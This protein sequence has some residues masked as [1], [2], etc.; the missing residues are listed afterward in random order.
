[1]VAL[2]LALLSCT[3]GTNS[4]RRYKA[5]ADGS[6][7]IRPKDYF[8]VEAPAKITIV[9]VVSSALAH[10]Y[11]FDGSPALVDLGAIAAEKIKLSLDGTLLTLIGDSGFF[12]YQKVTAETLVNPGVTVPPTELD[13]FCV[14]GQSNSS[15]QFAGATFLE[16]QIRKS[17][18][19][20]QLTAL[21][22]DQSLPLGQGALASKQYVGNEVAYNLTNSSSLKI[23]TDSVA[24]DAPQYFNTSVTNLRC[25]FNV[26]YSAHTLFLTAPLR[27]SLGG[28]AGA[29]STCAAFADAGAKTKGLPGVWRAILSDSNNDVRNR[30]SFFPTASVKNAQGETIVSDGPALWGGTLSS[31]IKYNENGVTLNSQSAWTG[32]NSDGTRA[33]GTDA[34]MSCSAWTSGNNSEN[35]II[36]DA[37]S[38]TPTWLSAGAAYVD[39]CGS[40]GGHLHEGIY[41]INSRD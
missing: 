15:A 23:F 27:G 3:A 32:S 29:D 13:A 36:G 2:G 19:L 26:G 10:K 30:I 31:A 37:N 25:R 8:R 24:S 34:S 28:L 7:G 38:I 1:M 12:E 11:Y 4:S 16:L 20:F 40:Q 22:G 9:R 6:L 5:D 21:N 14:L 41:C 39:S 33:A 17:G 35:G 18:A